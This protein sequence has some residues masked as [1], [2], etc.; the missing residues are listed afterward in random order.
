MIVFAHDYDYALLLNT[1]LLRQFR[2]ACALPAIGKRSHVRD[3]TLDLTD[4]EAALLLRELN[5]IIDGD[6]YFLSD[7]VKILKAIR[8]KIRPEPVGEPLPPPPKRYAPPR[9]TAAR[10]RR[11]GR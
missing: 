9:A 2:L 1:L 10:R 11:A 8:A 6:R 5:G 7:R 3:M 4:D